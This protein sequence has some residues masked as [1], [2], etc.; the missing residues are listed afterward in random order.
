MHQPDQLVSFGEASGGG[1]DGTVAVGTGGLFSYD[2]YRQIEKQHEFFQDISCL[3]QFYAP[4]RCVASAEF[5]GT[6][7]RR[8]FSN[9]VGELL[10]C[11]GHSTCYWAGRSCRVM[12]RLP[13]ATRLPFSVITIGSRRWRVIHPWSVGHI[14]VDKIPFTII[15]V[16]PPRFFG[17]NAGRTTAG[18]LAAAH[19]AERTDVAFFAGRSG[20]YWLHLMGRRNPGMNMSQAQDVVQR[21]GSGVTCMTWKD[22]AS[23][24][25]HAADTA[26]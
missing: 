11:T 21:P 24:R 13:A 2:F 8:L 6:S 22:P 14:T 23:R 3:C 1:V 12:K 7:K 26:N 19:H 5:S 16:A 20:L 4:C 9:G 17:L 15:G 10:Q 25:R 18:P